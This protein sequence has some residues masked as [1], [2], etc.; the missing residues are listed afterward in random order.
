M[1]RKQ[2]FA[3]LATLSILCA[4]TIVSVQAQSRNR[5]TA[6]VPFAFQI[7][8]KTLPAGDYS[9]KRL[10]QNALLVES[11]DGEQSA[12]AQSPRSVESNVN[13][14]PGTEKLVFR[15]YGDQYFLAQ[16][17]MTRSNTGRAINMT[18]AERKAAGQLKLAQNGAKP[19]IIEISAR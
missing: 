19:Q 9:V 4:L 3:T 14:K 18:D 17:W 8:D 13:A 7:G 5:I 16:V 15:Q 10:S 11:A 6:H 1:M 2:L 12:V